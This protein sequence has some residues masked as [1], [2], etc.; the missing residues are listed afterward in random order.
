MAHLLGFRATLTSFLV[1]LYSSFISLDT[2][3]L[4]HQTVVADSAL[5]GALAYMP[6]QWGLLKCGIGL[7]V[8]T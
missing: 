2:D 7:P 1:N 3:N 6:Y 4:A 5:L 8:R